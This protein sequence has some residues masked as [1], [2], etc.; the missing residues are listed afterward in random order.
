MGSP[1]K[2][3]NKYEAPKKLWNKDRIKREKQLRFDYGLKNSR[4]IW[5]AAAELK[6][7]RR[8]A[9]RL[10]SMLEE[11][12]K[13]DVDR[14]L[15]RLNRYNI[16]SKN[17][18]LEDILSLEVGSILERR[19]QTRVLRKGLA[20]TIKQARQLVSHGFIAIGDSIVNVP[21]HLTTDEEDSK[22]KMSKPI[23]LEPMVEEEKKESG[24]DG[25]K[26]GKEKD[27][28]PVEKGD[29]EKKAATKKGE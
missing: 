29:A 27:K 16:L 18:T 17:S 19:L 13:E 23:D 12:R 3:R 9:R 2:F 28:A 20:K 4:E 5:I 24:V 6:K 25:D 15:S 21:S 1:R 11:D 10:L 14:I 26:K 7:Y 22:L 8:E